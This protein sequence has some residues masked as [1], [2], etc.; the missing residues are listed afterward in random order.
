M[1][2][3]TMRPGI[4]SKTPAKSLPIQNTAMKWSNSM[5]HTAIFFNARELK[6]G[7]VILRIFCAIRFVLPLST[8]TSTSNHNQSPIFPSAFQ[9]PSFSIRYALFAMELHVG[10]MDREAVQSIAYPCPLRYK[11]KCIFCSMMSYRMRGQDDDAKAA[12]FC[13]YRRMIRLYIDKSTAKSEAYFTLRCF[14][15]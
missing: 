11:A 6:P 3:A 13:T 15:V 2:G 12:C 5:A 1:I 14:V 9:S 7:I 10:D 4:R 8:G